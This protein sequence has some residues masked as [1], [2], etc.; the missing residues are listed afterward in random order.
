MKIK[1]ITETP[2]L[3]K[4]LGQISN[5]IKTGA[6]VPQNKLPKGPVKS[7]PLKAPL[8]QI[9]RQADQKLMKPGKVVPIPTSS[10]QET[11]YE[12]DQVQGDQVKLKT[13]RPSQLAPQTITL[14]K[15]DLD[16]VITNINRRLK[17][18]TPQ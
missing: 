11:D 18:R 12:I 15:K 2:Y 7:A 8:Q 17:S 6:P 16:P 14:T 13:N 5:Q 3:Q 4:T 1:E 9:N 10:S